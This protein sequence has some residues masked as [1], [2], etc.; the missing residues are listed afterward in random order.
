[1][2][3]IQNVVLQNRQSVRRCYDLER[4][5]DPSLRGTL[6]IHFKLDPAGNVAFA[7]VNT[8]RSSLTH[9]QLARCAIDA[10]KKM[11][12]P[13]SSRGF[14]SAVNYPFDFRS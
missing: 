5:K 9:P 3:V 12:F 1:M 13:P 6:T 11:K 7:Q 4:Q 14:E 8:E 10:I 2:E